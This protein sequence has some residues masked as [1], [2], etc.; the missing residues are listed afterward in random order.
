MFNL[1]H[2]YFLVRPKGGNH[3][4]RWFTPR[5]LGLLMVC[6]LGCT[7]AT[8]QPVA[9]EKQEFLQQAN[10]LLEQAKKLIRID[11]DSSSVLTDSSLVIYQN[12]NNI[13]GQAKAYALKSKLEIER[14]NKKLSMGYVT[15]ALKLEELVTNTAFLLDAYLSLG[16]ILML[17]GEHPAALKM[18]NKSYTIG[19]IAQD[20]N[21]MLQAL[22]LKSFVYGSIADNESARKNLKTTLDLALDYKDYRTAAICYLNAAVLFEKDTLRADSMLYYS[23]LG[24]QLIEEQQL[25]IL[26][27]IVKITIAQGLMTKKDFPEAIRIASD[28]LAE[29][30][31]TGTERNISIANFVLGQIYRRTSDYTTA[32]RYLQRSLAIVNELGEVYLKIETHQELAKLYEDWNNYPQA[33]THLQLATEYKNESAGTEVRNQ[34]DRLKNEVELGEKER[35][36]DQLKLDNLMA[37]QNDAK[38]SFRLVILMVVGLFLSVVLFNYL[39]QRGRA[40]LAER[41]QL[42]AKGKL[43][44]LRSQMN[45]HFIYNAFGGIQNYILKSKNAEAVT[46]LNKFSSLLQLVM[47]SAESN[48]TLL[49]QEIEVLSNYL[50]LEGMRFRKRFTYSINVDPS[51]DP[52]TTNIPSM[53]VQPHVENAILHGLSSKYSNCILNINFKKEADGISV[54]I[55]DNGIGRAASS[56]IKDPTAHL[57]ISTLNGEKRVNFLHQLG[58]VNTSITIEDLYE[59]ETASGTRVTILLPVTE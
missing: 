54:T 24:L 23:E 15:Q 45:P 25:T 22:S 46:Y 44:F 48:F 43:G 30:D 21:S 3:S 8:D 27:P 26:R 14:E 4:T 38:I 50:D 20:T 11:P 49:A 16:R 39:R 1:H 34:I 29:L 7:N 37:Q 58:Y 42:I 19:S 35:V 13:D 40:K 57:S 6:L 59:N 41:D 36:I 17:D 32:E 12:I 47:T 56:K 52:E 31:T 51:I 33:L 5:S 55:T 18:F 10:L 2:L 28:A 53:M 9:V